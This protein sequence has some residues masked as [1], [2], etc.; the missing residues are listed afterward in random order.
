MSGQTK[1]P[2]RA[3]H[4]ASQLLLVVGTQ[5][6]SRATNA[7]PRIPAER[8]EFE[9]MSPSSVHLLC[10]FPQD[11]RVKRTRHFAGTGG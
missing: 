3:N 5:L 8:T 7:E 4:A 9:F 2:R 11:I 6:R 10:Q 1:Q